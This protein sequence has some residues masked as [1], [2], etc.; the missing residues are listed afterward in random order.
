MSNRTSCHTPNTWI[1]LA[2]WRIPF[3]LWFKTTLQYDFVMVIESS[4]SSPDVELNL[5]SRAKHINHVRSFIQNYFSVWICGD[6][7]CPGLSSPDVKLNLLSQ[8]KHMK[9]PVCSL[10][11]K[12]SAIWLCGDNWKKCPRNL[13]FSVPSFSIVFKSSIACDI[14]PAYA[15]FFWPSS[16]IIWPFTMF[17]LACNFSENETFEHNPVFYTCK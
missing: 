10:I 9:N 17:F 14:F 7:S 5:L 16:R 2:E 8:F 11:Q 12:Y 4:L 15:L 3:A 1:L 13:L 6:N